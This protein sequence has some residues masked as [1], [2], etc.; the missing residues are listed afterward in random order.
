MN[1]Q[2]CG[3][4][5]EW[6]D[7]LVPAWPLIAHQECGL[8]EVLGGIGHLLDHEHFCLTL[9]DPDAGLTYRES[10]KLVWSWVQI[11]GVE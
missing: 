3:E 4:S 2:L 9:H 5:I 8:R 6:L 11:K 7:K 1:C 10:A